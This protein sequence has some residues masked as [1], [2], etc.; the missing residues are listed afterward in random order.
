MKITD[1]KAWLLTFKL[2]TGLPSS[3]GQANAMMYYE[4][5]EN[6]PPRMR[7]SL[8]FAS[9]AAGLTPKIMI[10]IQTDEGVSGLHMPCDQ[11]FQAELV[12]GFKGILIGKDPLAI[13]TL[14]DMMDRSN[15]R[16]RVGM[17]VGAIAAIDC[18]LWDLKGK[19]AGM[20]VYKLL[21][22]GRERIRP[23]ISTLGSNVDDPEE[24]KKV[25][26]K[27]RDE[28]ILCQKWFFRYGPAH[29]FDGMNKNIRLA[30]TLRE[31]LGK[32]YLIAFDAWAA[33]D[34]SYCLRIFPE[35][36]G[37]NPYW[38]EE[39]LRADRIEAFKTLRERTNLQIS[40]GE[41]LFN[42]FEIHGFLK[43]RLIDIYQP[44]PEMAGGITEI[45]RMGE[46]CELYGVKYLPHGLSL[47][48]N[49]S[50][51]LVMSPDISPM[52]E[53]LARAIPPNIYLNKIAPRVEN[54]WVS[55]INEPGMCV[56]DESKLISK[57]LLNI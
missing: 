56:L 26:L 22:G 42:R 6:A 37:M 40:L 28:G 41:K 36:E 33:W 17:V 51:S 35:L 5:Y 50:V 25:A 46:L 55:A 13:R 27:F 4:E 2:D 49:L 9:V 14:W 52:F 3:G 21:G 48:P 31:A 53:G 32:D 47:M 20:P 44:E 19:A 54:G 38:I 39:P 57:D 24:I 18:A 7:R 30:Y 10:E 45:M 8:H 1:I 15:M 11:E 12:M 43:E 23:Y 16:A 34:L 29:G